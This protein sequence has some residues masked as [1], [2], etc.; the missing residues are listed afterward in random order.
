VVRFLH[1]ADWQ[2]GMTRR[3]LRPEAQ[4]RFAAARIDAIRRVGK[5]AADEG[6]EFVVVAGDVFESNQLQP[7]T[8]LRALEALADVP[9]PVH[10][11]PG[12]HD[13][14]DGLSVYRHPTFVRHCPEHVHVLDTVGPHRIRDGVEL[15]AAPW[16][17]KHPDRDLVAEALDSTG[18]ADG[19]VRVLVGHGIV[20]VLDPR[21]ERRSAIATGPLE[22]ALAQGRLHFVALGDRHSRTP[23]GESGAIWY[24]GA[25]EVTDQR[26]ERPGDVLVVDVAEGRPARVTPHHVG[27]W[28]FTVMQRELSGAADVSRLDREL[29]AVPAKDRTVVDLTLRGALGVEEFAE[30]TAMLERHAVVFAG[31]RGWDQHP[32]LVVVSGDDDLDHAGL[33]GFVA[34]AARDIRAMSLQGADRGD[35]TVTP[36]DE[37]LGEASAAHRRP[38]GEAPEELQWRYDAAREDDATSARDALALL[39]RLSRRELR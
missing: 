2:I 24:S 27:T 7:Q 12:N 13:P 20:D 8:V 26:E 4:A 19:T 10:L 38:A 32:D 16:H 30:L 33:G 23:V 9:V 29:R 36:I 11:L 14:L 34:A 18:P 1:S 28:T 31:L 5:V 37:R 22:G 3:W 25:H 39:F 35:R 17:G 6:C 15:V 21:R